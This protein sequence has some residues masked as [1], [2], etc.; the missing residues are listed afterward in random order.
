MHTKNEYNP[1]K[2]HFNKGYITTSYFLN[3]KH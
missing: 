1:M 3:F 2:N